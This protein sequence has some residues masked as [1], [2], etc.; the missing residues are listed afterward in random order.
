MVKSKNSRNDLINIVRRLCQNEEIEHITVYAPTD[1]IPLDKIE[2]GIS[3]KKTDLRMLEESLAFARRK[4][5]P[6]SVSSQVLGM[7]S[8][9]RSRKLIESGEIQVVE[10]DSLTADG[11][12]ETMRR[13][14]AG[15]EPVHVQEN[16]KGID[17]VALEQIALAIF[18]DQDTARP[19]RNLRIDES[20]NRTRTGLFTNKVS[21]HDISFEDAR[22]KIYFGTLVVKTPIQGSKPYRTGFDRELFNLRAAAHPSR[23][24]GVHIDAFDRTPIPGFS[25]S[26]I[27]GL[28]DEEFILMGKLPGL[29]LFEKPDLFQSAKQRRIALHE[30]LKAYIG[31]SAYN[32]E[33]RLALLTKINGRRSQRT[34]TEEERMQKPPVKYVDSLRYHGVDWMRRN[35]IQYLRALSLDPE[36]IKSFIT[37]HER[38]FHESLQAG[39]TDVVR[40]LGMDIQG[41]SHIFNGSFVLQE[42]GEVEAYFCDLGDVRSAG[43]DH[44]GDVG[45]LLTTADVL[46]SA[47]VRYDFEGY[48]QLRT[49]L[50]EVMDEQ[51]RTS[52][53]QEA[54]SLHLL[55]DDPRTTRVFAHIELFRVLKSISRAAY[56]LETSG[57]SSRPLLLQRG[58]ETLHETHAR[59][60]VS[61]QSLDG[62]LQ[63][64]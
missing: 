19:L 43:E 17:K 64:L 31:Y 9:R 18:G 13:L 3:V 10:I 59:E 53:L 46:T 23:Y 34:L 29:S 55:T 39:H 45:H 40:W 36:Q 54:Y 16:L 30:L 28:S 8:E 44:F 11:R 35:M 20:S 26:H 58:L 48:E 33:L 24:F 15:E 12:K 37:A 47:A 61:L 42:S 50:L 52:G 60:G 2:T 25:S 27:Y 21:F 63:S 56:G 51:Y 22:G 4:G 14:H 7:I 57:D 5:V 1:L 62:L 49:E 41:D 38:E 32:N 6:V